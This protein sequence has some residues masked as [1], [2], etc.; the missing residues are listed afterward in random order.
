M[1]VGSFM[2]RALSENLRA[3]RWFSAHGPTRSRHR[4]SAEIA[5]LERAMREAAERNDFEAAAALRNQLLVLRHADGAAA[6]DADYAG[7][8]RQQPGAMGIGTQHPRPARPAGW[9]PPKK[10]GPMTANTGRKG[11]RR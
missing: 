7:L 8:K 9:T 4:M 10:P 6:D 2:R 1:V 5:E 11:K 3:A